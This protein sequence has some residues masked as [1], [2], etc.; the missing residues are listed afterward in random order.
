MTKTH[1][2]EERF[3]MLSVPLLIRLFEFVREQTLSDEDLHFMAERMQELALD[4]VKMTMN[5]Y[6]GII[7]HKESMAT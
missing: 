7:P 4:G 3:L 5:Q 2:T 1:P 6:S